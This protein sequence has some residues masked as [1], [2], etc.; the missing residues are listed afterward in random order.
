MTRTWASGMYLFHLGGG[1]LFT[2]FLSFL[3]LR[4]FF[5]DEVYQVQEAYSCTLICSS[6]GE[7]EPDTG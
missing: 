2:A 3:K 4:F 1:A 5:G 7:K 6:S